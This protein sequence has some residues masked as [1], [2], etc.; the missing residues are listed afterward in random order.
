M[1]R[2][3]PRQSGRASEK[4]EAGRSLRG[5][6]QIRRHT[7]LRKL[8]NDRTKKSKENE[9]L[10]WE[11]DEQRREAGNSITF[12]RRR[13]LARGRVMLLCRG[14]KKPLQIF[15]TGGFS[16]LVFSNRYKQ[17]PTEYPGTRVPGYHAG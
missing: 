10:R 4:R 11:G 3:G 17:L 5:K 13:N 1:Q 6:R 2:D 12:L 14:V 15:G 9:W 7:A 16:L 8:T